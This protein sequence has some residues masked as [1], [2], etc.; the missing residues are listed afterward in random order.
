MPPSTHLPLEGVD[1]SSAVASE[2]EL[3]Q[4][5]LKF[6]AIDTDGSGSIDIDEL[7]SVFVD[8]GHEPSELQLQTMVMQADLDGG[9]DKS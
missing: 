7:R 9:A 1:G 4:L 5:R 2:E 3:A 6:D 8:L